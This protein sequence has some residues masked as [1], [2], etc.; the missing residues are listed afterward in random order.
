MIRVDHPYRRLDGAV[1]GWSGTG[2][3]AACALP[4]EG[5]IGPVRVAPGPLISGFDGPDHRV[6]GLREVSSRVL[7][8]RTVAATDR[9]ARQTHPQM[10]PARSF[11]LASGT[12][13]RRSGRVAHIC[14]MDTRPVPEGPLEGKPAERI[15]YAGGAAHRGVSRMLK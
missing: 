13:Q 7:L 15:P 6:P 8:R 4:V 10:R 9:P 14:Q 3:A 5:E 12:H 2:S 11:A 1:P